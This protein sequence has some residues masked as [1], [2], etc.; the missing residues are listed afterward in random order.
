MQYDPIKSSLGRFF[1]QSVFLRKFFY[2][3][4]DL[5]LLRAWHVHSELKKFFKEARNNNDV[6]ILDA[7]SGFGQYSWYIARKKPGWEITGVE[8]KEDQVADCNRFFKK[9]GI[10][11]VHFKIEN[12]TSYINSQAYNYILSVDVMEHIEEDVKVFKNFYQSLKHGG[13]LIISTPSDKGGSGVEHEHDESFIE[14]HVR[15]GYSKEDITRKLSE[16]GFDKV[17][18]KYT[19]GRPGKISWR[20]SM[21]YPILLL[22]K[23]KLFFILLP[24]YYLVIYPFCFILNFMDVKSNHSSGTGLLVTATK[25]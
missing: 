24:L 21:K 17:E 23:S 19:Y 15:D 13:K 25:S 1:N 14:E 5:L 7:G 3:L 9:A 22:G 16:A 2:R 6:K 8:I 11:N 18:V 12:L 10:R 4:L 20:L